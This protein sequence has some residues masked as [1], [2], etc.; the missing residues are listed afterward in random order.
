L[1]ITKS[2]DKATAAQNEVVK[3]TYVITNPNAI[4]ILT[5]FQDNL[6]AS[7]AGGPFQYITGTLTNIGSA[8]VSPAVYG[9]ESS[10]TLRNLSIPASGSLTFT[11]DA[12]TSTFTSGQTGQNVAS[13]TPDPGTIYRDIPYYSGQANTLIG[14]CNAGTTAPTLSATSKSNICPATTTDLNSLVTSSCPVGSTLEWHNVSTGLSAS[15][16]ITNPVSAAGTYYPTCFDATNA[17]Y[18]I[19]P[20]TGVTVTI[21]TCGG[22]TFTGSGVSSGTVTQSA[23]TN[24]NKSGNAATELLPTGGNPGYTYS[25]GSADPL[26]VAPVGATAL[27]PASN[28]V[29]N[30]NGSY[31]YTAPAMPGTYYFCVKVCDSTSPTPVCSIA[32]YKVVVV[33]TCAVGSAV[34]VLKN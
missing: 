7:T 33:A 4:A 17:C 10:L 20:T 31:T 25:N 5:T 27:P 15:S 14:A 9:G 21:T 6:P 34:P 32:T 2:V 26:C 28:L 8:I 12:N 22:I 16:K 24:E 13:V 11:V 23:N 30:S 18:S 19:V 3:Y 29:V 1:T